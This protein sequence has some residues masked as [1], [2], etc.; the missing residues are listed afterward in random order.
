VLDSDGKHYL[1]YLE[2]GQMKSEVAEKDAEIE[3]LQGEVLVLREWKDAV[4]D[5]TVVDW[6]FTKAH[7]SDPRKAVNDLLAWQQKIALDP[8]VSKEAH[9]LHAVIERLRAERDDLRRNGVIVCEEDEPDEA[10]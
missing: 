7:E 2:A 6:I 4:I 1:T 3:R 5:A 8:A 9:D 10:Q